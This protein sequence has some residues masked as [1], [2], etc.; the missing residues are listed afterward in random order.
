MLYRSISNIIMASTVKIFDI[1]VSFVMG[2]ILFW[3]GM[4]LSLYAS[5]DKIWFF[6]HVLL[7]VAQTS[8]RLYRSIVH[9]I[10]FY[11]C[12]FYVIPSKQFAQI[13]LIG[14]L[15]MHLIFRK[16]R[17]YWCHSQPFLNDIRCFLWI[18]LK[19]HLVIHLYLHW[20]CYLQ[21][22][23]KWIYYLVLMV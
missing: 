16:L 5:T 14:V 23:L 1:I 4:A 18:L 6:F 8:I 3:L 12:S 2:L 11:F 17:L 20:Q 21:N 22:S 7:E 9:H 19:L 15:L 13:F 10:L